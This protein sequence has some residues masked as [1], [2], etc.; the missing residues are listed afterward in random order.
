VA[1][2]DGDSTFWTVEFTFV[3]FGPKNEN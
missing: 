2:R 1:N 3:W